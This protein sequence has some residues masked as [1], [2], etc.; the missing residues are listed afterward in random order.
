VAEQDRGGVGRGW[1]GWS[2]AG[3]GQGDNARRTCDG[4][5]TRC[6]SDARER[7]GRKKGWARVLYPL[8]LVGPTDQPANIGGLAYMAAMAPYVRWASDEHKLRMSV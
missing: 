3:C 2:G 5:G 1:A 7:S 4:G 8:M 6:G